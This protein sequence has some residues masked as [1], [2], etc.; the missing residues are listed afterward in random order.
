M[1]LSPKINAAR[2]PVRML[3]MACVAIELASPSAAQISRLI[4]CD[5][6]AY[7]LVI[8]GNEANFGSLHIT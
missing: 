3:P 2:S 4:F 8:W 1:L 7:A 6:C 5:H